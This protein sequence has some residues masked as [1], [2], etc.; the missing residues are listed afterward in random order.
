MSK[1]GE[2]LRH[3][4]NAKALQELTAQ[5]LQSVNASDIALALQQQQSFGNEAYQKGNDLS[6]VAEVRNCT[7]CGQHWV[8]FSVEKWSRDEWTEIPELTVAAFTDEA[9]DLSA[10]T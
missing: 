5:I 2:P 9:V 10:T 3:L 7:K 1:K 6:S 4:V 8:K